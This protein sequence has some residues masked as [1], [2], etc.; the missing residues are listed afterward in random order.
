MLRTSKI[1]VNSTKQLIIELN[2][3]GI[4]VENTTLEELAKFDHPIIKKLMEYK[5]AAKLLNPFVGKLPNYI[6]KKTGR[7]HAY[8]FQ[9]GAKSGRLSCKKSNLQQQHPEHCLSG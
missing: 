9:I 6:N 3:L 4:P 5:E 2:Q 7:V 8:F 1:N